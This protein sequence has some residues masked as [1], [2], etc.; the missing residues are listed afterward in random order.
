MNEHV[1]CARVQRGNQCFN[2]SPLSNELDFVVGKL[3][4]KNKP[5]TERCKASS[6]LKIKIRGGLST[7]VFSTTFSLCPNSNA[8]FGAYKDS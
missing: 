5:E 8:E 2:L 1:M 6:M 4:T 7:K 3:L